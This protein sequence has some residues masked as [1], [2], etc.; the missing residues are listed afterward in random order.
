LT[1]RLRVCAPL[2]PHG[3]DRR[4]LAAAAHAAISAATG[5][6]PT[7]EEALRRYEASPRAWTAN[8]PLATPR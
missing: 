1:L 7:P 3:H 2:W 6:P 4:S 5:D 8:G